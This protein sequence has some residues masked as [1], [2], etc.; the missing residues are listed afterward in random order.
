MRF[1]SETLD[2]DDAPEGVGATSVGGQDPDRSALERITFD[3]LDLPCFLVRDDW[4]DLNGKRKP[5]VWFCYQSAAAVGKPVTP[6]AIRI[7]SPLYVA[8]VT[9]TEDGRY[10]G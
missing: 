4:F 6:T 7:C 9:H 2:L 1:L 10:F 8:A 5:G 3:T